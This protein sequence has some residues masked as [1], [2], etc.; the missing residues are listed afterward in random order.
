MDQAQ[1]D[2]LLCRWPGVGS[3]IKWHDDRAYS[4]GGKMFAVYCFQGSNA[5]QVSFKV[6]HERFLE[7]TDRHGVIPAPY[8]A[9]AH[10]VSVLPSSAMAREELVGLLRGS[11][12]MVR[13]K[14]TR[15]VQRGLG[16][17]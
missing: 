15:K 17:D 12:E 10:W 7:L 6:D 14:L 11:Y 8:L 3:D 13:S 4:V 1:I 2:A 5:G 9:R 16:G